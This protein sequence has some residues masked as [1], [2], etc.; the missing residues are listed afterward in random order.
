MWWFLTSFKPKLSNLL[1][2]HNKC[3]RKICWHMIVSVRNIMSYS[4]SVLLLWKLLSYLICVL[5]SSGSLSKKSMVGITSISLPLPPP[6]AIIRSIYD[7][8]NRV[9]WSYWAIWY[10]EL[11]DIFKKLHFTNC[12]TSILIDYIC[13][14]QNLLLKLNHALICLAWFGVAFGVTVLKFMCSWCSLCKVIGN[15][16]FFSYSRYNLLEIAI[17]TVL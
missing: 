2:S 4:K 13:L 17:K 3:Y 8:G 14:K 12:F 16:G 10:T 11:Q 15:Q 1:Y 5:I 6:S 9:N 7:G